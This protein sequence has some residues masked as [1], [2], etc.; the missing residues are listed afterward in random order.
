[1]NDCYRVLVVED[2][3]DPTVY[4]RLVLLKTGAPPGI[5][6]APE[7][8]QPVRFPTQVNAMLKG[9]TSTRNDVTRIG[10]ATTAPPIIL[11]V[12]AAPGRR[13]A[14]SAF[15]RRA[16]CIAIT[17]PDTGRP[18]TGCPSIVPDLLVLPEPAGPSAPVVDT[19]RARFPHCPVAVTSVLEPVNNHQP[20]ATI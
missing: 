17:V 20:L 15:F 8:Q 12:E 18:A 19:L 6:Q 4:L 5:D 1:V 16:G 2:D 11:I 3:P 10:T 7:V 9:I 13:E 14:L